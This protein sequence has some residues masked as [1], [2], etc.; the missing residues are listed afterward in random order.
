MAKAI[1]EVDLEFERLITSIATNYGMAPICPK[2]IAMLHLEGDDLSLEEISKRTGYSLA[3]V[4]NYARILENMGLLTRF[5]KPG[6]KRIY[7]R[8]YKDMCEMV[9]KVYATHYELNVKPLREKLPALIKEYEKISAEGPTPKVREAARERARRLRELHR[10]MGMFAK[11]GK[12]L[13]TLGSI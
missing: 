12:L 13:A 3:S 11:I 10:K 8:R 9:N 6:A 4:S 1:D 5:T 2:M 7:V